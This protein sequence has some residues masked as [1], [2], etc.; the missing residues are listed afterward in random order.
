M[1]TTTE[2]LNA[3][4]STIFVH[5][6]ATKELWSRVAE[7]VDVKEIRIPDSAGIAGKV[8]TSGAA[9]NIAEPY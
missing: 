7:G 1:S 5:D 6:P 9:E 2:L 4:R 3:D 8:F